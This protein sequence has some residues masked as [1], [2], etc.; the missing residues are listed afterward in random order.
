MGLIL[1]KRKTKRNW[2]TFGNKLLKVKM[3]NINS[4]LASKEIE[5]IINDEIWRSIG[6]LIS[7]P[8]LL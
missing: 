1:G 7:R 6:G 5:T 3:Q 8:S 4:G 2:F